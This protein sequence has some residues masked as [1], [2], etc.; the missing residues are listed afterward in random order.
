MS[1][2]TARLILREMELVVEQ[3]ETEGQTPEDIEALEK[4]Y[5]PTTDRRLAPQASRTRSR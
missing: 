3:A 4:A 5:R 1:K 2:R